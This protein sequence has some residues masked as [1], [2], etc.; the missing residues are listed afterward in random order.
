MGLRTKKTFWKKE[1][2]L[3]GFSSW[4]FS[5][6]PEHHFHSCAWFT[7][8]SRVLFET[9]MRQS[10]HECRHS[11]SRARI[12][13]NETRHSRHSR[14]LWLG[15]DLLTC[16]RELRDENRSRVCKMRWMYPSQSRSRLVLCCL[17]ENV[18][19]AF[20]SFPYSA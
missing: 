20:T 7:F 14:F 16:L 18:N 3:V 11:H 9:W 6:F 4:K 2:F 5:S 19:Q 12:I 15:T 1:I 17:D 8:L 10:T 13:V